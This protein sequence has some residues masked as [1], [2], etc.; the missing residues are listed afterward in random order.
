VI[1][2]RNAAVPVAGVADMAQFTFS[3]P[4]NRRVWQ[5]VYVSD[6]DAGVPPS[7][8]FAT[9]GIGAIKPCGDDKWTAIADCGA[10][11]LPG[12][13]PS[14]HAA[15]RALYADQANMDAVRAANAASAEGVRKAIEKRPDL[16]ARQVDL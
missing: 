1:G 3:A 10:R 14:A 7:L 15:A 2:A 4:M 9:T 16:K 6:V 8:V 13:F 12:S 11:L 5:E